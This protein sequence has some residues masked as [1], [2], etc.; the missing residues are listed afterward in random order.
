MLHVR[1]G[2][3]LEISDYV[4][5][6]KE[7]YER[8]MRFCEERIPSAKFFVFSDDLEWCKDYLNTETHCIEFL[9][10]GYSAVEDF[11]LMKGFRHYIISNSTFGWWPAYLS[12]KPGIRISPARWFQDIDI[13]NRVQGALL[14][15]FT[16][17]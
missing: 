2:D 9:S 16:C 7:Y 4:V 15:G 14:K 11:H 17:I 13:N 5:Q 6:D 3:Y 10:E 1:R 8:A 12:I